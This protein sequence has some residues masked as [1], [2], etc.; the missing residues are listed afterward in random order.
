MS[1]NSN[2]GDVQAK[3]TLD[4]KSTEEGIKRVDALSSATSRAAVARKQAEAKAMAQAEKYAGDAVSDES[5]RILAARLQQ[6]QAARDVADVLKSVRRGYLDE[7]TG[8]QAAAAAIQKQVAAQRELSMLSQTGY[9]Q[10]MAASA[11]V[12][13]LRDGNAG[14]RSVE[15]F[16]DMSPAVAGAIS[17]IFPLLGAAGLAGMLFSMGEKGYEAFTKIRDGA[18]ATTQTFSDLHDKAQV[19]IDDLAIENQKIQDQIDKVSGRPNNGLASALLEAKKMADELLDSLQDDRKAIEALLKEHE[20]GS[21]ASMFTGVASTG[22]QNKQMIA[23]QQHLRDA[24]EKANSDYGQAVTGT[25]DQAK[26]KA[27][28]DARNAAVRAAFQSQIDTYTREA[29]RLKKEQDD[30]NSSVRM[31]QQVAAQTGADPGVYDTL[32]NAQKIA[33]VQGRAQQLRDMMAQAM[34]AESIQSG[35]VKLGGLK[36]NNGDDGASRKAAEAQMKGWEDTVAKMKAQMADDHDAMIVS[37]LNFWQSMVKAAEKYPDNLRAVYDKIA[38]LTAEYWSELNR[39][40]TQG[41]SEQRKAIEE[42]AKEWAHLSDVMN[43][44]ERENHRMADAQA[45]LADV[46][47]RGKVAIAEQQTAHDLATGSISRYAAAIQMAKLH[48]QAYADQLEA[49][50]GEQANDDADASLDPENRKV[51]KDDRD[52]KIAQLNVQAQIAAQS[53][54]WS[55]NS[56]S[57]A[58]GVGEAFAELIRQANDLSATLKSLTTGTIADFNR[59]LMSVLTTHNYQHRFAWTGLGKSL[60]TNVGNKALTTGEGT[61]AGMFHLGGI[62]QMGSRGNP[63]WTRSADLATM[64]NASQQNGRALPAILSSA[65]MKAGGMGQ[66]FGGL[67]K[68]LFSAIPGFASGVHG[69]GGGLALVGE[70]GPEYVNIPRGSSVYPNGTPPPMGGL[71]I[72]VDATGSTNPAA[73]AALVHQA[74]MAAAPHIAQ[75]TAKG[76]SS[77]AQRKPPSKRYN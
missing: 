27:A 35:R 4:T 16:I 38:S 42:Q 15:R 76:I 19:R 75:A 66:T 57:P 51:R 33:N 22:V 47:Q 41:L 55:I 10:Q 26:I 1:N 34:Y 64:P 39:L 30:S 73:T 13:S 74:I 50:R 60:A 17:G 29:A 65:A 69:F 40:N 23:D 36:Q 48:A 53:D 9:T 37:E 12:R 6:T 45:Q 24:I 49:L 20:V 52:A 77:N 7:A 58:G 70:E 25:N 32:N 54:Q 44:A 21:L 28:T 68:T 8:A 67:A 31:A 59:T 56:A 62:G 14:I 2:I 46:M 18:R 3:M 61:V 71:T 5:R 43:R 63:M 11:A 72:H